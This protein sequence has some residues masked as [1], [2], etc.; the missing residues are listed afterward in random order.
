MKAPNQI[1]L[2]LP[3]NQKQYFELLNVL[4]YNF[5]KKINTKQKLVSN[6]YWKNA[7]KIRA[8]IAYLELER[9]EI[10]SLSRGMINIKTTATNKEMKNK[11]ESNISE[12]L[13]HIEFFI[14]HYDR[15]LKEIFID[16]ELINPPATAF[17]KLFFDYKAQD[18]CL[19][20]F[21]EMEITVNGKNKLKKRGPNSL[22]KL[23]GVVEA[24]QHTYN[25]LSPVPRSYHELME[26]ITNHLSFTVSEKSIHNSKN[27]NSFTDAKNDAKAILKTYGYTFANKI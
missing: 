27:S 17:E 8:L 2:T 5:L 26:I 9:G 6:K 15:R 7:N 4:C 18:V 22:S 24:M 25:F 13:E 21:E 16:K 1:D 11:T 20:I 23:R 3:A 10:N 14:N 12:L 19:K